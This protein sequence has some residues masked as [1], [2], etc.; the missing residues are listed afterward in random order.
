MN[1]SAADDRVLIGRTEV[2]MFIKR[3]GAVSITV[4]TE[5]DVLV[6]RTW[7]ISLS[8]RPRTKTARARLT[9]TPELAAPVFSPGRY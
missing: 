8:K 5:R 9:S 6:N 7:S 2:L 1:A 4:R 3:H